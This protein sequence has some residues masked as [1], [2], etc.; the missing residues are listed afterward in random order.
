VVASSPSLLA[1]VS[2]IRPHR[3]T[4]HTLDKS[5]DLSLQPPL[6][7]ITA[8]VTN[9]VDLKDNVAFHSSKI[10]VSIVNYRDSEGPLTVMD[11]VEKASFPDRIFVGYVYQG[12]YQDEGMIHGSND[13]DSK[14]M[15]QFI[16]NNFRSLFLPTKDARGPCYARHLASTL[17]ENEPYYLQIDSHMRFRPGWDSYLMDLLEKIKTEQKGNPVITTYP[18]GYTLPNNVPTDR[19]AT[20]LVSKVC[21][22]RF[23]NN[24]IYPFLSSRR[25]R[26]SST[27]IIC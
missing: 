22:L 2:E 3:T 15:K 17:W 12:D 11:L 7:P 5:S 16:S 19:R 8:S 21:Y 18:L 6:L 9:T 1:S 24:N 13:F 23:A 10:F 14:R 27:K 25:F 26:G 20:V 4:Q